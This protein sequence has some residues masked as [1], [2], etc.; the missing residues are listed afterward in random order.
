MQHLRDG[1]RSPLPWIPGCDPK[2]PAPKLVAF[3][4]GEESV[5][6]HLLHAERAWNVFQYRQTGH[7]KV[8]GEGLS[9]EARGSRFCELCWEVYACLVAHIPPT[10]FKGTCAH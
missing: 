5:P 9:D 3:L 4:F 6:I 7:P 2:N 1:H 10:K 8:A